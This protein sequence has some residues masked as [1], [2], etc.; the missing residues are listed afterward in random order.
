VAKQLGEDIGVVFDTD[1]FIENSQTKG[2][3]LN[4]NLREV[5]SLSDL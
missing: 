2:Y 5:S 1:G 3:R 4:R